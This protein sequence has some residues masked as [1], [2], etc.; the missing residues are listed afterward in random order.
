PSPSFPPELR[1][2]RGVEI[3]AG[4]LDDADLSGRVRRELGEIL[5]PEKE[6]AEIPELKKAL[7]AAAARTRAGRS[8]GG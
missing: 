1:A 8:A 5:F 4:A 7:Y 2:A 6:H 3:L